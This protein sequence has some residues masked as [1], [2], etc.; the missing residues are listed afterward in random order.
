MKGI[1]TKKEPEKSLLVVLKKTGGR[2]RAGRITSRHRGGGAK[3]LYRIIDFGEEHLGV[4]GKVE[5]IEYD[6][7]RDAFIAYMR[8]QNGKTGYLLA[9]HGIKVGDEIFCDEKTELNRGNRM[10]LKHMPVGQLV[11]N[12]ELEP[13]RG[14]KI[15]KAAGG[16]ARVEAHEGKYTHI[17]LPSSEVR[18]VLEECFASIG[19]VSNPEHMYKVLGK[20][21]RTRLK[22]QRPHVRGTAMNAADHPHGGGEGKTSTGLKYPK[23]PWGK[24]ALGV[25]TRRRRWT[26]V[27]I[28]QRRK[29]K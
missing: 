22:G 15:V 8:Y 1:L 17:L 21:G 10:R 18:K 28:L 4:R 2:S 9:P 16:W 25:K 12:V 5:A 20:A 13:T 29:K 23:T 7:N 14:G 24:H 19:Q 6:P 11:Y 26:N 3:R 27:F